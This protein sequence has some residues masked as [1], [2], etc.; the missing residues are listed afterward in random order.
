MPAAA[1]RRYDALRVPRATRLQEMSTGNKTRFHLPDG[2]EQERARRRDG[3]GRDRLV[4][5]GRGVDLRARR[6]SGYGQRMTK[7]RETMQSQP[8][9][10]ERLLADPGPA[11][12]AASQL[13]G[14]R[15]LLIGIGT[16]WHAAHHGAWMLRSAGVEAEAAHAADVAPYG[17][18]ID[19]GDGVIVLSHTGGT[20]YSMEML[21]RARAGRRRDG[22]HL[23]HRQRRRA[24]DGQP[25]KRRTPTRR[26]TPARSCA[27]PR[28]PPRSA[29]SSARSTRSPAESR[30]CST[31]R[32]R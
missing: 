25:R 3:G 12:S 27:S 2:P 4:V 5:Q 30:P 21:E 29:R 14:R 19:A 16:S 23:R 10:L 20:G 17:R 6:R 32:G 7:M 24:R 28:S 9:Q 18:P 8:E 22:A 26:A 31:C 15:L 13:A 1:L 11:E